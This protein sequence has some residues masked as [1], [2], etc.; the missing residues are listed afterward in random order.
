MQPAFASPEPGVIYRGPGSKSLRLIVSSADLSLG[1]E[2]ARLSSPGN[3][4]WINKQSGG[5]VRQLILSK[6]MIS[7]S[8]LAPL[9]LIA[10]GVWPA[11]LRGQRRAG[12]RHWLAVAD[13]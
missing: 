10:K 4:G 7:L 3:L 11:G 13:A 2:P 1:K 9:L 6:D 12:I 8:L 5:H